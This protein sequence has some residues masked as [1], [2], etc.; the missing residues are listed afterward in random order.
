MG[1]VQHLKSKT[2]IC[3]LS[4]LPFIVLQRTTDGSNR[5]AQLANA[6]KN[7]LI[8]ESS[9]GSTAIGTMGLWSSLLVQEIKEDTSAKETGTKTV[10]K[11][12]LTRVGEGE[13]STSFS[14]PSRK[15][16]N[17]GSEEKR[18]KRHEYPCPKSG[19]EGKQ[20]G[21]L[22]AV[23]GRMHDVFEGSSRLRLSW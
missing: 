18:G 10:G 23:T 5:P 11:Y 13:K 1:T 3:R 17:D 22:D 19:T 9:C 15:P 16:L 21:V 20:S 6:G 14:L 4:Q 12:K 7:L 8:V 2:K